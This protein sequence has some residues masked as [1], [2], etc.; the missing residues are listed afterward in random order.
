MVM[1]LLD[2]FIEEFC[3]TVSHNESIWYTTNIEIADEAESMESAYR[4]DYAYA[5]SK[6][7]LNMFSEQL[8]SFVKDQN[9]QVYAIH[10]G[11]IKTDMGGGNAPGNPAETAKGIF[12]II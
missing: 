9:I 11:W 10:P 1:E 4:G 8:S 12:D 6:T 5:T 3:Q 2:S 7:A